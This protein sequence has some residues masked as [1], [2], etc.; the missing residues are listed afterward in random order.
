MPAAQPRS[1]HQASKP[2]SRPSSAQ[3]L[4]QP[5]SHHSRRK[6]SAPR[7]YDEPDRQDDQDSPRDYQAHVRPASAGASWPRQA[8]S[9]R[10]GPGAVAAA[11]G[12]S[13]GP[14]GHSKGFGGMS[15]ASSQAA[16]DSPAS[17]KLQRVLRSRGG[18]GRGGKNADPAASLRVANWG[19]DQLQGH[20]SQGVFCN[21]IINIAHIDM[22]KDVSCSGSVPARLTNKPGANVWWV[23]VL[24]SLLLIQTIRIA[25]T[26]LSLICS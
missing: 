19:S 16:D 21:A 6:R 9:A 18:P 10:N 8:R 15:G 13:D 12:P 23:H 4:S 14:L 20:A 1:T 3:P 17:P 25:C 11:R 22:I 24:Q 7:S 2:L 26:Q 5:S